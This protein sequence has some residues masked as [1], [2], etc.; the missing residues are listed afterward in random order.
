MTG[1]NDFYELQTISDA[2]SSLLCYQVI[3]FW[4]SKYS[5]FR[6]F[7]TSCLFILCRFPL[8]RFTKLSQR[9]LIN[10]FG[11]DWRKRLLNLWKN[12]LEQIERRKILC[13]HC[14]K[15]LIVLVGSGYKT[16]EEWVQQL[17]SNAIICSWRQ[18]NR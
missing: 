3:R 16:L 18:V 5:S 6:I 12:W 2:R 11:Q 14:H 13:F 4:D 7:V 8:R 17:Y 9:N 15:L 1:S 10:S